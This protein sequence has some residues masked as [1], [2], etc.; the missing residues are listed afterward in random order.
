MLKKKKDKAEKGTPDNLISTIMD[1]NL[2]SR[3][4]LR[5]EISIIQTLKSEL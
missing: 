1:G 3:T 2:Y 5:C 4:K